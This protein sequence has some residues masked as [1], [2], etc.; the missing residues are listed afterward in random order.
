MKR[1]FYIIL[2][3]VF[4]DYMGFGLVYPLF[5]SMMFDATCPLLPCDVS[6]A[7][8]G[9]WL[10]LLFALTP[11]VQFFSAPVWGAISDGK[12]RKRPLQVSLVVVLCGYLLSCWG[13]WGLSLGLLLFSRMVV[14]VGVGNMSIVQAAIADLSTPAN[15]GRYFSL[16]SM[17]LGVGFTLGPFFGGFLSQWGYSVPFFFAAIVFGLNLLFATLYLEETHVCRTPKPYSWTMGILHL[18]RAM[19]W[20]G[21][22]VVFLAAFLHNFGWT[23]FFEFSPL[24]LIER[25]HFSSALLGLYFG[26][27]GGFY[28]FSTGILTRPFIARFRPQTLFFW[29]TFLSALSIYGMVFLTS[30]IWLWPLLFLI[31]FFVAFVWPMATTL[32][33]DGVPVELQGE[34]LG[35]LTSVMAAALIVSCLFSGSFVGEHPTLPMWGGASAILCAALVILF[36]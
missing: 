5:S 9:F 15:K 35:I 31:C 32:V 12:G 20:R 2:G 36:L 22:R 29:G 8:R 13:V 33:S 6:H 1:T 7:T 16:Y 26:A 10:G 25:F 11:L 21:I 28:A 3:I 18:H 30:S 4:A 27:S 19:Q 23:F 14:G 24:F 17:A 34:G